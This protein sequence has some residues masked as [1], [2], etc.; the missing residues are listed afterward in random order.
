MASESKSLE[1]GSSKDPKVVR[2]KSCLSVSSKIVKIVMR[3][4]K[5][6][7]KTFIIFACLQTTQIESNGRNFVAG[8][9][10]VFRIM[11]SSAAGISLRI[12]SLN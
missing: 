5:T 11:L 10:K 12:P 3:K 4:V 2:E 6:L 9:S 7:M 8:N 1:F